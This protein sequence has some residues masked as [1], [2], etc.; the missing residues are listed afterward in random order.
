MN[1]TSP[2]AAPEV[3]RRPR[4]QPL[5]TPDQMASLADDIAYD[6]GRLTDTWRWALGDAYR[7]PRHG[8]GAHVRGGDLEDVAGVVASTERYRSLLRRAA[9]DVAVARDRLRG[10]LGD[11]E[12]AMRLLEPP[13]GPEAADVRLLPHPADR[14]DVRRATEAQARRLER[15]RATGDWSEVQG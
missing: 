8:E 6:A 10:A 13:P 15:A 1:P 2:G 4:R 9:E 7:R 3:P 5:P 14:G 12:A 11:L